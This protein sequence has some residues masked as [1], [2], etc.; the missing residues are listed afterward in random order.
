[1]W[2]ITQYPAG[3]Y[4]HVIY[5]QLTSWMLHMIMW[6]DLL[7]TVRKYTA[8]DSVLWFITL[9]SYSL[10]GVNKIISKKEKI[11]VH[12]STSYQKWAIELTTS[13]VILQWVASTL[14]AFLAFSLFLPQR[15]WVLQNDCCFL[16]SHFYRF[17]KFS[18][19][20]LI[21]SYTLF[22]EPRNKS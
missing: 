7:P 8:W 19:K 5:C 9:S 6:C 20:K 13:A 10:H 11:I 4:I 12:K 14:N 17:W 22:P 3:H 1:M 18:L 16:G 21:Q 2:F 15:L